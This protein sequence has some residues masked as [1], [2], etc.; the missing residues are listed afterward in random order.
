MG[1]KCPLLYRD[2]QHK[3]DPA[4]KRTTSMSPDVRPSDKGIAIVMSQSKE[5]IPEVVNENY[6]LK[7]K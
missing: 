3:Q 6:S 7:Q 2:F 5:Q 1:S 4:C